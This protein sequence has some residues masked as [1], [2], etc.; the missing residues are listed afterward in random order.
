[1][2]ENRCETEVIDGLEGKYMRR[3]KLIEKRFEVKEIQMQGENGLPE[4]PLTVREA[5]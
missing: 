5:M 3:R 4:L 1:M 2:Q